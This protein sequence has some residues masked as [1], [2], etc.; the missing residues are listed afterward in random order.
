MENKDKIKEHRFRRR[1]NLI[2]LPW[3]PDSIRPYVVM[4]ID[5]FLTANKSELHKGLRDYLKEQK[6][7][8][9]K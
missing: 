2:K 3:L 5:S 4:A 1:H 9:K 8:L 7:E 6:K